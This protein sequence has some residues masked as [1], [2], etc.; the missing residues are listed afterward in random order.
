MTK[1][2]RA[3]TELII[4]YGKQWHKQHP[5]DKDAGP[6]G[7][8]DITK[9]LAWLE[10]HGVCLVDGAI[11]GGPSTIV[12][13]GRG[14]RAVRPL[15]KGAVVTV[16]PLLAVAREDLAV[17]GGT[18][19]LL[20][21]AFGHPGSSLLLVPTAPIVNYINH[22]TRPNVAI[23]WPGEK[24]QLHRV[25]N[26]A[27]QEGGNWWLKSSVGE[28]LQKSN[29]LAWEYVALRD[30]DRFEELVLDYGSD[31]DQAWGQFASM[32]PYQR[33]GYFRHEIGVPDGFYPKA[34]LD[35]E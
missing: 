31:W 2:V 14:A 3:G 9:S 33:P 29:Q 20:N 34:W 17:P 12:Q 10:E 8:G 7:L 27:W 18:Q 21:Y 15:K 23:R 16:S 6:A 25:F 35:K 24:S 30:I 32:H 11:T 19:L 1:K 26:G 4:N 5:A 22:G 28:V 13:A